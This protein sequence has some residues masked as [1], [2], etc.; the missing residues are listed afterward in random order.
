MLCEKAP[1]SPTGTK[2]SYARYIQ[3]I[4]SEYAII[5]NKYATKLNKY[6]NKC[7]K[8][9]VDMQKYASI[10]TNMQEICYKYARNMHKTCKKYAWNMQ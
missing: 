3:Q 7:N 10:Y 5:C 4:C 1:V 2:G 8:H 9:A 6:A